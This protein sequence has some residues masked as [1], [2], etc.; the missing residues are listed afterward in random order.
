M[1]SM[2][3]NHS[4]L[5]Q[6]LETIVGAAGILSGNALAGRSAGIWSGAA[7][8]ALALVRPKTTEELSRVMR[9][10]HAAG[11]VV[12]PAGGMT[13]LAGGHHST[14]SDIL[15]STERMN[16]IES[17]DA[18]ARTMVVEAGAILQTVQQRAAEDGLMFALDLGARASC[19][20]GGNIATNAGGVRVLR[21][22]MMREQLLGLEVV[23]ADGS[24]VSSMFDLLK[25][26]AGYDLRQMFVGSE[27]TLG[28]IT[29]AVLRL[30]E[31]PRAIE[32]A[33]LAVPTWDQV[34]E[35]L[36]YFDA[37]LPGALAAFEVLWRDY[38]ELNT[39]PFS[40]IDAPLETA[41]PFYVLMDVFVADVD[42]GHAKL[43][44]LLTTRLEQGQIADGALAT[45]EAERDRFWQIRENFEPEQ[46]KFGLIYG[47]DVSLPRESMADYVAAVRRDLTQRFDDAEL[48]AY[49]HIGDGNLHFSIYPGAARDRDAIDE[50]VYF[51]LQ[52]LRGSISAEHGI[53]LEKKAYLGY[54]RS[55]P[56]IE[57]MRRTKRM[58]DPA[59][60]LNPGKVFDL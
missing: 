47:Y 40:S 42:A 29:R 15:L 16:R 6:R 58:L 8:E 1:N 33:L 44:R 5:L 18:H 10:C 21:Y 48:F 50:M 23:L 31:A 39:G 20:I 13:G 28:V 14:S 32:T 49:G 7:L 60:I 53:G 12:V 17:L 46:K 41:S 22:G 24:V 4:E 11:Q 26:N 9:L 43:E 54:T 2:L 57:L 30:H 55:E 3:A 38:Y 56:E 51:P 52:A 35:L 59:N 27:G 25:N 36:R 45:S 34:M 19:T 37:A